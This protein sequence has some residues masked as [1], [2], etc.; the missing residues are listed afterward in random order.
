MCQSLLQFILN[1]AVT[2]KAEKQKYCETKF[3]TIVVPVYMYTSM[4]SSF[5]GLSSDVVII[6]A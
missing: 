6:Y 3:G 1:V 2:V 5:Q 4:K